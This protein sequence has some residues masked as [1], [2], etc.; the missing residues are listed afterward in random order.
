YGWVSL[1]Q[2]K[3]F[4]EMYEESVRCFKEVYYGFRPIT[5]RGWQNLVRKGNHVDEDENE[6]LDDQGKPLLYSLFTGGKSII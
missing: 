4:F 3:R 5:L 6:V 2:R 1:R